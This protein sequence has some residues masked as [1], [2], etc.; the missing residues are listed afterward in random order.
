[1]QN[2]EV[3]S[4]TIDDFDKPLKKY[5][6]VILHSLPSA[7][8]AASSIL[9]EIKASNI[10]VW[11]FSGATSV[12]RSDLSLLSKANKTNEVEPVMEI[13]FPL[14]TISD[15]LRTSFKDFPAVVC[16][17]GADQVDNNSNV[18]LYQRIGIVDTKSP[19]MVFNTIGENKV[20]LFTGEGIWRW[21]LQ[22]F[23]AHGNHLAFDEF[24]SKTVQYLSVKE[25]KSFFK[26]LGKNNFFENE[27][28]EFEAEVY[29]ESY[30]L[31]NDPEVNIVFTNAN[32]KKFNYSFSKTLNAYRLNA[33]MM[34]VGEYKYEAQVKVGG[35]LYTQQGVYSVTALQVELT[36]TV[37]DHQLLF[38]LS[39]KH[40]GELL[41]PSQMEKLA[42]MLNNREDIKSV[43]FTEKKLTDVINLKGIFFLVL[44]LLSF[45]WFLRKR[46]GSY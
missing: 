29:N 16:P 9:T 36:N 39:K 6:L 13:N 44:A 31:I 27:A 45:E 1:N 24:V 11:S 8:N 34:P 3:E 4:Y 41:Y 17:F 43:S 32:N 37:A 14:F 12:I 26:V 28:I 38:S 21:R 2:Y 46:N 15:E 20:A 35:K 19:L 30:E 10:P 23:A 18:I 22:D 40:D 25:D 7:R 42:E 33:G 5:N